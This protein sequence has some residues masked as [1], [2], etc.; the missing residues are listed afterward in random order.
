MWAQP[1]ALSL[2]QQEQFLATAKVIKS[3]QVNEGITGIRRLTLTDGTLTHDAAFQTIDEAKVNFDAGNASELNFRDCWKYSV[4]AYRL[5]KMLGLDTIPATVERKYSG[6]TGALTWWV[7]DVMMNQTAMLQK[8]L[9]PPDARAW[10]MQMQTVRVFDQLIYNV[11]RNAGN[12]L[13]TRDWTLWMI[14]HTR[15]FRLYHDLKNP[16]MLAI[17]DREMFQKMKD[18]NQDQLE[19]QLMPYLNRREIEGVLARRDKIV[20]F[21]VAGGDAVL[22]SQPPRAVIEKGAMP[23]EAAR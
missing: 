18:L 3:R 11:D 16:Q 15:A 9:R 12:L 13:I 4:A 5:G 7:D 21:F 8:H 10:N 22:F 23:K 1:P 20:N 2:E 14:D 6:S 19:K 17:C